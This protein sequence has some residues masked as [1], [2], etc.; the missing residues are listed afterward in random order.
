MFVTEE[1]S[2]RNYFRVLN[3]VEGKEM[4][5]F[6]VVPESILSQVG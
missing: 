1:G 6:N 5:D 4:W 2:S 3:Y